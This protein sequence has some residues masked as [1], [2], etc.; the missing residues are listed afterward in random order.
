MLLPL[1]IRR[2]VGVYP[3]AGGV[4]VSRRSHHNHHVLLYSPGAHRLRTVRRYFL[5]AVTGVLTSVLA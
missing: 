2:L 5:D 1:T 4:C 3:R